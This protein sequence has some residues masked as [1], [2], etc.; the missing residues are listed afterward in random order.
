MVVVV[1]VVAVV[2]SQ[3]QCSC[4]TGAT[5][6][7]AQH[8]QERAVSSTCRELGKVTTSQGAFRTRRW[9]PDNSAALARWPCCPVVHLASSRSARC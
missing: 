1:V 8:G 7:S 5:A 3:A 6:T 4:P 2:A 9:G